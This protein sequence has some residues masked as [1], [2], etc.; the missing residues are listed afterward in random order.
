MIY[1]IILQKLIT[2]YN[3]QFIAPLD[4]HKSIYIKSGLKQFM[5]FFK[6]NLKP[7]RIIM[8]NIFKRS[9]LLDNNSYLKNEAVHQTLLKKHA[10]FYSICLPHFLICLVGKSRIFE[11]S[12]IGICSSI[13]YNF[14]I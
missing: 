2:V 11:I 13:I 3:F 6:F 4:N 1:M 10:N 12:D 5:I 7:T 9:I 14:D 8:N